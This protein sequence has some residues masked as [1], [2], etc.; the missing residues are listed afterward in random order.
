[1]LANPRVLVTWSEIK[2]PH[3]DKVAAAGVNGSTVSTGPYSEDGA[4][5]NSGVAG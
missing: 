1:M 2:S 5:H 4:E 3:S